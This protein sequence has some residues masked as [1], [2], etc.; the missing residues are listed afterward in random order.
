MSSCPPY[1][2]A[3]LCQKHF[4]YRMNSKDT[5]SFFSSLPEAR[6]VCAK[7]L[8]LLLS[9][10]TSQYILRFG[11]FDNSKF[12]NFTK[13]KRSIK[14]NKTLPDYHWWRLIFWRSLLQCSLTLIVILSKQLL[15]YLRTTTLRK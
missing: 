1:R 15:H 10:L 13:N 6:N 8:F 11:L 5:N 2:T 4:Q 9:L 7:I 3:V 14:Y 12:G